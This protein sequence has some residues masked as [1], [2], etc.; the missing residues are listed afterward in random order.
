M[1]EIELFSSNLS[2]YAQ[3][4]R[5]ALIEKRIGFWHTEIDLA[6]KPEWFLVDRI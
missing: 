2:P 3:R 6:N 4:V 5:L 1:P